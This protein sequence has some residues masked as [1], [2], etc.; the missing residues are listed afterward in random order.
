RC[1]VG[2]NQTPR[3]SEAATKQK[4]PAETGRLELI[5]L[6]EPAFL[7]SRKRINATSAFRSYTS[8]GVTGQHPNLRLKHCG[9]S[10]GRIVVCGLA[11]SKD[12]RVA[13]LMDYYEA[14]G[15]VRLGR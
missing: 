2:V 3:H 13:P 11:C 1:C 4:R 6:N 8:H 15:A 14:V 7:N 10:P 9:I 12:S 5:N